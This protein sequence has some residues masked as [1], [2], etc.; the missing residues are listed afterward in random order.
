MDHIDHHDGMIFES[1][2]HADHDEASHWDHDYDRCRDCGISINAASSS[3]GAGH[4]GGY[5]CWACGN[6][7]CNACASDQEAVVIGNQHGYMIEETVTVCSYHYGRQGAECETCHVTLP[8]DELTQCCIHDE[9]T[10]QNCATWSMYGGNYMPTCP[11][12]MEAWDETSESEEAEDNPEPQFTAVPTTGD[13]EAHGA[14]GLLAMGS[15]D[16]I[17]EGFTAG[18]EE[19]RCECRCSI[20]GVGRCVHLWYHAP[21]PHQC[22][23]HWAAGANHGANEVQQA[24]NDEEEHI[25]HGND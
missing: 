17:P 14:S 4:T 21:V 8:W 7:L 5:V 13:W 1:D 25:L 20:C 11:S 16:T 2:D 10:C 12:C 24:H 9:V 23:R 3:G 18:N 19:L 15:N 22:L 6:R